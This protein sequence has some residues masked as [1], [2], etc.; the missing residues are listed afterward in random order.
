MLKS[1]VTETLVPL[2]RTQGGEQQLGTDILVIVIS[3]DPIR[4]ECV[5]VTVWTNYSRFSVSLYE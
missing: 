2:L 4:I 5:A 1:M 3:A